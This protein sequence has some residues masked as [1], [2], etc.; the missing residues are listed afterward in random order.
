MLDLEAWPLVRIVYPEVV[1]DADV[2][3]LSGELETVL[4]RQ[5]RF[6]MVIDGSRTLSLTPKQ[7]RMIVAAI[8]KNSLQMKQ[9]CAGQGVIVKGALARGVVTALAWLKEPPVPVRMFESAAA[10]EKWARELL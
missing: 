6:T 8:D 5:T 7:R 3:Q 4:A 1:T 10:A 2:E 9:Y